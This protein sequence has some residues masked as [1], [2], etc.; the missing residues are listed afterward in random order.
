MFGTGFF[1]NLRIGNKIGLGFGLTSLLFIIVIVQY[2]TTLFN[3]L[4]D[5]EHLYSAY[6]AQKSHSLNIHRYMLEA[7][8]SEKDFL[9]RKE[10]EYVERVKKYVALVLEETAA[11]RK[12]EEQTGGQPVGQQIGERME[13]YHAAFKDIVQAWEIAGLD[14]NSGLQGHFRESIHRVET[15]AGEFKTGELYLTLLQIRRGEKD[16]SLR[17][18]G[19]YANRVDEFG[20]R[21]ME[22]VE[23]SKLDAQIKNMLTVSMRDY[24]REFERYAELVLE[25]EELH[26]GKGAFRNIAHRLEELISARYVPDMAQNIL[27]LRRHEKDYLQRGDRAYVAKVRLTIQ[28]ILDNISSSKI[29]PLE[30]ESLGGQL[31]GYEKD[32]FALVEQNDRIAELSA[33]MRHAVHQIEP[34]VVSNV[35]AAVKSMGEAAKTTRKLSTRNSVI[36]LSMSGLAVYLGIIFSLFIA[37]RITRP[38]ATLVG[39]AE[40]VT[41]HG[42]DAKKKRQ[43]D[44]IATLAGAMGRMA[45]SHQQMLSH[46]EEYVANLEAIISGIRDT[47]DALADLTEEGGERGGEAPVAEKQSTRELHDLITL[48][49]QQREGMMESVN[50]LKKILDRYQ[51]W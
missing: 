20:Q 25:G 45:G 6:E 28:D 39:L 33:K 14:H 44:E 35:Q 18:S 31:R 22:Q 41:G 13:T 47:G 40:L 32:F 36:A 1:E 4:S 3:A 8:R 27:M 48:L 12:I 9:A 19:V 26:G 10:A 23:T 38:V 34:L 7:R 30:K 5:Y 50:G 49:Q 37:Q 11:L 42:P 43:G 29:P 51:E 15:K 2:H 17:R 21:F 24:L 16:R 46:T